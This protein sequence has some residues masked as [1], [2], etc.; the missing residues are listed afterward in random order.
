VENSQKF[1]ETQSVTVPWNTRDVWLGLA[2]FAG[3]SIITTGL[4][5]LLIFGFSIDLSIE[6]MLII[7]ELVFVAPIWLFAVR[8]YGIGWKALGFHSFT[9]GTLA[10]GFG[11]V[12]AFYIITVFYAAVIVELFDSPMQ[13][14]LESVAN[15]MAVPWLL[16][17]LAV[18]VAPFVEEMFFRGF[19][20][21]GFR[22]RYGWQK[23][24]MISSGLFAV[25][26]LQ[27]LAIV[28]LFMLG[29]IFA[30]LYHRSGSIWPGILLHFLVNLWGIIVEFVIAD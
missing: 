29:Y 28:P 17:A 25:G 14:S 26:H 13:P 10:V 27:P 6:L 1:E 8:K 19:V 23:A 16:I 2:V 11:L 5:L 9:I 30:Y 3:L 7:G 24:A 4:F 12:F 22:Q 21:A 20:F 15:E 18:I